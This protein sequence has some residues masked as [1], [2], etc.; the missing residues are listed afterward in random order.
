MLLLQCLLLY[1]LLLLL[2]HRLVLLLLLL[3]LLLLY[4]I[5][6]LCA[7]SI[8][9]CCCCCCCCYRGRLRYGHSCCAHEQQYLAM[10]VAEGD[11]IEL[12]VY[13]VCSSQLGCNEP[14]RAIANCDAFAS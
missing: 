1:R 10:L 3:L 6:A 9:C 11:A 14:V 5:L 7:N 13:L 4:L 8:T 2:L 12:K